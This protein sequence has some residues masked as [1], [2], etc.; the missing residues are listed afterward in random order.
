VKIS[1]RKLLRAGLSAAAGALAA[2]ALAQ[3]PAAVREDY[4]S[5]RPGLDWP[6]ERQRIARAW[7]GILGDFPGEIPPLRPTMREVAHERGITRYHVSFNAEP[8]DRVTGWLLV[9]DAAR[10]KRVPAIVCLHST[11]FGSGKDSTIGLAGMRPNDP[12]EQWIAGYRSPEVGQAYGRDLARHGYVTLSIDL[13]ND[14]ERITGA[15]KGDSRAFYRRHPEWS[16]VGKNTWDIMRSVDFLQTLHWVD[17]GQIGCTGWSLGGHSTLF[18][19]AFDSRINAAISNGGVLDWHRAGDSWARPDGFNPA[20]SPELSRRFG[21]DV[22]IGPNVLIRKARA[23][24]GNSTTPPPVGFEHLMM[25]VAPR[26]LMIISTEQ[27]FFRHGL[28]PKCLQTARF[29]MEWRDGGGQPSAVAAR[30]KR[31]GYDRTVDYYHFHHGIEPD[32]LDRQ[33]GQLSAGD[34]FSWFSFPGGH[35]TPP[36]ARQMMFAWFD[37]WLG[38]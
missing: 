18:A 23:F 34:C 19:A 27:E 22:S 26:P 4:A 20:P 17:A 16:I 2:P 11:T 13:L 14:G 30:R 32:E 38:R 33:L 24:V 12:A 28:L 37:R 8:D 3:A 15:R 7:L 5:P 31:R 6:A 36:A 25:M 29:Y 9:P 10:T 21:F 1:R 35:S